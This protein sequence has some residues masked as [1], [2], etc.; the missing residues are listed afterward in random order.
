MNKWF[1][2]GFAATVIIVIAIPAY[3]LTKYF[4]DSD[5]S[6][7]G[8]EPAF[9]GAEQCIDCHK[10]EYDLWTG[11][12]HDKAMEAATDSSVLADFNNSEFTPFGR[13]TIFSL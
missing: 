7:Y 12:H 9:V 1:N 4:R 11:S 5:S 13:K 8:N 3:M 10:A 2:T 6:E